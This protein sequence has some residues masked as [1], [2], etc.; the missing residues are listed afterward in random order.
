MLASEKGEQEQETQVGVS[1]FVCVVVRNQSENKKKKGWV[2]LL[3][4][5]SPGAEH[6]LYNTSRRGMGG[7]PGP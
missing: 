4:H 5:P 3:G 1:M 2:N 7:I 6:L